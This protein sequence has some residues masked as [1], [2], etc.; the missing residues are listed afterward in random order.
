MVGEAGACTPTS[1]S[2][3]TYSTGFTAGVLLY[4]GASDLLPQVH[5]RFNLGVVGATMAGGSL[6]VG[7]SSL[8]G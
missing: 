5:R 7:V 4:V 6:I 8:L 1:A 3:L 2:T